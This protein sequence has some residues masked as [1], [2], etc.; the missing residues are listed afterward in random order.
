[1]NQSYVSQLHKCQTALEQL[2]FGYRPELFKPVLV[3]MEQE[4]HSA[5]SLVEEIPK[6]LSKQGWIQFPSSVVQLPSKLQNNQLPLKAEAC[7]DDTCWQLAYSND[8]CWVLNII[9]VTECEAEQA[10]HLAQTV[11]H[12]STLASGALLSYKSLWSIGGE[13][14]PI[15]ALSVFTGFKECN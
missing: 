1:M 9:K 2:N 4:T 3:E 14:S 8:N 13:T 15:C 11:H 10:S 12:L 6:L 5:E 7:Q